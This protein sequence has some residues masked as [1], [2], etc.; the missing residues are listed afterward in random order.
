MP[1]EGE[2]HGGTCHG[3]GGRQHQK[4]IGARRLGGECSHTPP[5]RRRSQGRLREKT[6]TAAASGDRRGKGNTLSWDA[7]ARLSS[8]VFDTSG[9]RR[10]RRRSGP[11]AGLFFNS[12]EQ[13]NIRGK[14]LPLISFAWGII[15]LRAKAIITHKVAGKTQAKNSNFGRGGVY[16]PPVGEKA[17]S[18]N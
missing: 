6:K 2:L 10:I 11:C 12:G 1:S 4:R 16:Q 13:R 5:S 7:L 9:R 17:A 3:P 15:G 14:T 18:D 8:T